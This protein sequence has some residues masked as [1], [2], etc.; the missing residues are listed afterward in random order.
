MSQATTV[1]E[2]PI[3]FTGESVRAILAG[4]KTQTRRVINLGTSFGRSD[5]PGYD[6]T[7]R[8]TRRGGR[9]D[10]WQDM[11]HEQI[12]AL[13]P[14]GRPGEKLWCRETWCEKERVDDVVTGGGWLPAEPGCEVLY[15]ADNDDDG[16]WRSPMFMPRWA[17]R[18]TLEIVSVRVERSDALSEE[19]AHAEGFNSVA[20]FQEYWNTLNT[21]RGFGWQ[22]RPWLWVL[23]FRMV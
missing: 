12:L 16:P 3:I 1:S 10:C 14:F 19:D 17:S 8:G 18:L 6:W 2:R 11:M 9:K 4:T 5:T 20:E 21:K 15:R 7:F 13:C 23:S 22:T